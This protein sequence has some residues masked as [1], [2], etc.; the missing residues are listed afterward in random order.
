MLNTHMDRA[1]SYIRITGTLDYN[2][3]S[4]ALNLEPTS[5]WNVGD[6]RRNGSIYDF[7]NW[8]YRVPEFDSEFVDSSIDNIL[9][10]I[11]SK[12]INFHGLDSDFEVSIQCV[13]YHQ[14]KSPGFHLSKEVVGKLASLGI[15]I[16]FDLYCENE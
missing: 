3:V 11:E 14:E 1:Y 4:S 9:K 2:L 5:F 15:S 12:N 13:A 10:F 8:S 7:S 16:D 6:K